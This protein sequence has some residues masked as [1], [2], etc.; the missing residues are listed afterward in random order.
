MVAEYLVWQS[1]EWV[2]LSGRGGCNRG[3]V[4]EA[5]RIEQWEAKVLAALK[6]KLAEEMEVEAILDTLSMMTGHCPGFESAGES[7]G[8]V[9][10]G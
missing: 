3:G 5:W 2:R 9:E 1:K 8:G 10:E 4:E 6:S 7:E